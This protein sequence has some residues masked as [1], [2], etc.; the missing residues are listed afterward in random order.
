MLFRMASYIAFVSVESGFW[1]IR[2]VE[3]PAAKSSNPEFIA[4]LLRRYCAMA[5][6]RLHS[7]CG[8]TGVQS[9]FSKEIKAFLSAAERVRPKV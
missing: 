9:V 1:A 3:S 7:A 5:R 4:S 6:V 2:A 8:F